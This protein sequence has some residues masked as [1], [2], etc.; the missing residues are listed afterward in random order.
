MHPE[1][2]LYNIGGYTQI[3]G[4]IDPALFESAVSLL[5]QRHDT[6]RIQLVPGTDEVPIQI[7]LD[8]LS[9]TVPFHDFSL[10]T[11]PHESALNWM[12]KQFV[13][14]FELEGKP[15]FHFALLKVNEN[16]EDVKMKEN[17]EV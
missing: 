8:D 1:S 2:P 17:M 5:V 15:L 4:T 7:F 14:P 10:E 16:E 3:N 12:Q 13:Q 6:L 11:N 9:V